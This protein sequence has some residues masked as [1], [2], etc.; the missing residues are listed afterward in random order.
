MYAV[1]GL[2]ARLPARKLHPSDEPL[3]AHGFRLLE[4]RESEWG[5][6]HT[7]EWVRSGA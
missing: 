1:F 5:L 4:R 7:D 3:R 2:A 6:L